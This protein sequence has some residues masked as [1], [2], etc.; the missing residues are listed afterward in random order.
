MQVLEL[1]LSLLPEMPMPDVEESMD[2]RP[3][4]FVQD[5]PSDDVITPAASAPEP[6]PPASQN[7][8][9]AQL[10]SADVPA[11]DGA[12]VTNSRPVSR[13]SASTD[14][15]IESINAGADEISTPNE[16]LRT[17]GTTPEHDANVDDGDT[18]EV[19]SIPVVAEY[20][21]DTLASQ[22]S[23]KELRDLL[24]NRGLSTAGTKQVLAERLVANG[25]RP[26]ASV[27]LEGDDM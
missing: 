6:L 20:S 23:A 22:N 8:D 5:A 10:P 3:V 25:Y 12:T 18:I 13:L 21:A 16:N 19:A 27:I 14:G 7:D 11:A 2:M 9:I 4:V 1:P 15:E 17:D 24:K 26:E